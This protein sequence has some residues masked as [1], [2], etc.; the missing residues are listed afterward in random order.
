MAYVAVFAKRSLK[1]VFQILEKDDCIEMKFQRDFDK[2]VIIL[3]ILN[4]GKFSKFS[5]ENQS[6]NNKHFA[7]LPRAVKKV[8]CNMGR[9]V[10]LPWDVKG[11]SG[12]CFRNVILSFSH[13]VII[14]RVICS[15]FA[16]TLSAMFKLVSVKKPKKKADHRCRK[17]DDSSD[18]D[19]SSDSNCSDSDEKPVRVDRNRILVKEVAVQKPA[20]RPQPQPRVVYREPARE[21]LVNLPVPCS[22]LNNERSMTYSLTITPE[23]P[24]RPPSPPPQLQVQYVPVLVPAEQ[25]YN[26]QPKYFPIQTQIIPAQAPAVVSVGP[27]YTEYAEVRK[28][29]HHQPTV[30]VIAVKGQAQ[31]GFSYI[32]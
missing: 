26:D 2:F 6:G 16:F 15:S 23:A 10:E 9:Q 31:P 3:N 11:L 14:L 12:F 4:M 28:N 20:P 27:S 13:T 32:H 7:C 29:H 24:P 21:E 25:Q 5:R 30:Q 17:C 8:A 19:C 18:S 22:L 1:H